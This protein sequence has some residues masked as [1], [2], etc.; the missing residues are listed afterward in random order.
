MWS[1]TK[2]GYVV[3]HG[4]WCPYLSRAPESFPPAELPGK[5]EDSEKTRVV[6]DRK[7]GTCHV[8]PVRNHN[9]KKK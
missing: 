2:V 4:K 1:F 7:K 8:F 5:P 3:G 6:G 9:L